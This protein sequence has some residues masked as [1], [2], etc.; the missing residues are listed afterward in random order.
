MLAGNVN[1]L[2]GSEV[3][4]VATFD[5]PSSLGFLPNGDMVVVD[6]H[7]ATV[8]T[9]RR[10]QV[11]NSVDLSAMTHLLNDMTVDRHGW[12]YV[13]AL[14]SDP[15]ESGWVP[16]GRILLV[17]EGEPAKVVADGLLGP[18]G[19]AISPDGR[20]LVVGE[21]MGPGGAPVGARLVGYTIAEDGIL[22]EERVVGTVARGSGDGLCFDSEGGLWVGCSFGHE[23]QRFLGGEVV[24][25]IALSDKRWALA[26]ALGGPD[27]RTMYVCSVPPPPRGQPSLMGDGV[28]EAVE[29]GVPGF[30]GW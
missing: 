2:V 8:N 7:K 16:D 19:I 13:D 22:T 29:V 30:S 18:N 27:M 5:H 9:V 6:G 26:C 21:S 4:A 14:L 28:I 3:E 20:T 1:R 10:G 23:V 24:E 12:V 25:R 11:I 17:K 15:F